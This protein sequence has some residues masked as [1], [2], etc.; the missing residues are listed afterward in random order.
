MLS[1]ETRLILLN[2]MDCLPSFYHHPEFI[3]ELEKFIEK[4]C[5]NQANAETTIIQTQNLLIQQFYKRIISF[6]QKHF[7]RAPGFGAYEVYWLHLVVPNSGLSSKQMPKTYLI[8]Y[9]N[10]LSFV[11]LDSHIENYKDSKLRTTAQ[12]R[13][14][15]LISEGLIK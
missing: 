4:H 9:N 12:E 13:I 10:T 2:K 8:K 6:P 5:N 15:Q 7:G 14:G 11:C 1:I 3:E